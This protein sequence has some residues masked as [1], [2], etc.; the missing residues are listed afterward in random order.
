MPKKQ[1]ASEA[2]IDLHR[3]LSVLPSRSHE[4]R[5]IV[6]ETAYLI[7]SIRTNALSDVGAKG[8]AQGVVRLAR[9]GCRKSQKNSGGAKNK[10]PGL[11]DRARNSSN[12]ARRLERIE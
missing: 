10:T 12:C 1:L 9:S 6:Q 5:L 11:A 2:L 8:T 4:R 7:W 3:R